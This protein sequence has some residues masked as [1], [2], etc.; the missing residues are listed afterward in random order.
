MIDLEEIRLAL[1]SLTNER[2]R[3]FRLLKMLLDLVSE[4]DT[5]IHPPIITIWDFDE[6]NFI[7]VS[8]SFADAIGRTRQETL[9]T[10]FTEMIAPEHLARPLKV[11]E[12][13]KKLDGTSEIKNVYSP[14]IHKD[15][16][17]VD[18]WWDGKNDSKIGF[19]GGLVY[20]YE[21]ENH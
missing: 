10:N 13:N 11:Y 14:Y 7:Y 3:V 4:V 19:G 21:H 16:H 8:K 2:E 17:Q 20:L 18:F 6:P 1:G 5:T 9:E 12:D 15:G